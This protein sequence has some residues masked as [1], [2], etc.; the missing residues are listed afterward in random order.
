MIK[1]Y[2]GLSDTMTNI[3]GIGKITYEVGKVYEEEADP[4]THKCGMHFCLYLEDVRKFVP[5]C[6]H[7]IEIEAL[8]IVEG[9]GLQYATNKL[10]VI[11]EV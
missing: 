3:H 6:K 11:R 1:G 7:I 2:K 5:H 8:G 10:R 9:D 4:M